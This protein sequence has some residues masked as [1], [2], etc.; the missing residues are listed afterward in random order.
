MTGKDPNEGLVD[1]VAERGKD[2]DEEIFRSRDGDELGSRMTVVLIGS[3][4]R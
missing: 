3:I 4:G 2:T 1:V